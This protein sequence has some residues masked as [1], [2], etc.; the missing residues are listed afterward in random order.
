M[1]LKEAGRKVLHLTFQDGLWD[2]FIGWLILF[3][4]IRSL[5]DNP[6]FS[7]AALGSVLL[8]VGGKLLITAPRLGRVKFSPALRAR[9]GVVRLVTAIAVLG[10]V[11]FLALSLSGQ[12]SSAKVAGAFMVLGTT[13]VLWLIAYVWD[14]KRLYVYG[15][16]IGLSMA[17]HETV[18]R[19]IGPI[20]ECVVGGIALL[21]GLVVL[22]RFLHDY[23]I[24]AESSPAE[25]AGDANP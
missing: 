4:G 18:G 16:L 25:E 2:I 24:P 15:L 5:T 9:I 11:F 1:G 12:R 14:F 6:W 10:T 23:P 19:P 7:L 3:G 13:A 8:Y 21:V 20:A 22:A 17:L